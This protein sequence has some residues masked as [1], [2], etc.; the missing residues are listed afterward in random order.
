MLVRATCFLATLAC[1]CRC[2]CRTVLAFGIMPYSIRAVRLIIAYK[3]E[4]RAKYA[5][6]VKKRYMMG[7]WLLALAC[8]IIRSAIF[9]A[10]DPDTYLR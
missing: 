1:R 3:K 7:L 9:V 5:L 4:Y 8:C 6:Y 2:L 10:G